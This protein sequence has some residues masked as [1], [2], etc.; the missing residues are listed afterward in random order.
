MSQTPEPIP[1]EVRS[2]YVPRKQFMPFHMRKER[3][4]CIVAHRRA[5]KTVACVNDLIAR[6]TYSKRK[7]PRYAYIGPLL[8]QAKKIAWEY[9]KEYTQ[10]MTSKISESDLSVTLKHNGAEI[11]IY[12]ADNPDAFRG[13]YFD[14][15]ILDEYGDMSPSVWGKVLLPTLADRDGWA[16][17]IGTFK[18]KN[19]FYRVH[20]NAQGL[21]IAD[22]IDAEAYRQNWYHFI[23]RA[24]ESGI[25]SPAQLAIQ[26]MEQDEEEYK[27]E[28]ECDPNAAVKGTYYS[29]MI[30]EMETKG[31]I[32]ADVDFNPELPV[33]V[34]ADL[35]FNDSTCMWFW[36]EYTDSYAMIDYEE[37]HGK[38]LDHYFNLLAEKGYKYG[39]IWLPHDAVAE[40][41][42]SKR[43]TIEQ[44]LQAVQDGQIPKFDESSTLIRIA[45]KLSVQDGIAAVRKLLPTCR[46][47][48][49]TRGG[50]EGLR[51]YKRAWDEDKKIFSDKPDH[52]WA[53]NPS[54]AF[55]YFALTAKVRKPVEELKPPVQ[56][57]LT[58]KY[59]LEMLY[60][61]R[62]K[63]RFGD[64]I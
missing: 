40:T 63:R 43:S 62:Q 39:T 3:F 61:M 59:N 33:N 25:L 42:Q 31:N 36:Q 26:K 27:Q 16:A 29:K 13:Q 55:R 24:S 21:D 15:I 41:L 37:D 45:P 64:R 46:F 51:A 9:L 14:G 60:D 18:G 34:A 2:G 11:G 54:D 48:K 28:Y 56:I 44:F 58:P 35:G 49:R 32:Y 8:K 4:A 5:G 20:R 1:G 52:D 50:V 57:D 30:A 17:F 12:G 10:G 22:G 23:L 6:A 47:N 19:H 7:R 53:S 38:H